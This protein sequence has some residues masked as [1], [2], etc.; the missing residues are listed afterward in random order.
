MGTRIFSNPCDACTSLWRN[1]RNNSIRIFFPFLISVVFSYITALFL[2][3]HKWPHVFLSCTQIPQI[4]LRIV[5][6][7]CFEL[8]IVRATNLAE[9]A[10]FIRHRCCEEARLL[11]TRTSF[12]YKFWSPAYEV[13]TV[14]LDLRQLILVSYSAKF[15]FISW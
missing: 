3:R 15:R 9:P 10:N 6:C 12:C 11:Y 4:C 5:F 13:H 14:N 8:W 1:P 7:W 2:A